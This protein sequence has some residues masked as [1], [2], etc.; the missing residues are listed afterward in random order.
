MRILVTGASGFIGHALCGALLEQGHE[1]SALVRREGSAPP[2]TRALSGDL[3]DGRRLAELVAG[4]RPQCVV[5]LAAEIASQRSER[6]IHEVN[7]RGTA[8]LLDACT[9]LAGSDLASGPRVVF[10]STVVTGDARGGLL[11]EDE[12][13][14]VSTPYGRSKRAGEGMVLGSGLPA[15]VIRPSH[16]YGPGGWYAN[17]L[18]A[19]LRQPGRFAVIGT[20][21]N[22]W[23]VVH[24]D[25]V[26]TALVLAAERA[27]P[28]SLYHVADDEPISFYDFM[29]LTAAELGIGAPRRIPAALA[30]L[31]AG[32]NAVDAAVRS[33]RSSN[34][35]IKRQ[36][37]WQPR[38][39]TARLGVPDAVARLPAGA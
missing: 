39:A 36:L 9:A 20:G 17:E 21:S 11:S 26:V 29:A 32:R 34:A 4:E 18:I 16:V 14:P 1:V 3:S 19:H 33:A 10:S 12:P 28:G 8:N 37:G 25:D 15:V 27:A 22:L 23:D 13:L 31:V 30:R 24:V 7:V 5:H 2:G 38:F 6:K 35:K